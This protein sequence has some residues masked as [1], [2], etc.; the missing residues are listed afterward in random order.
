MKRVAEIRKSVLIRSRGARARLGSVKAQPPTRRVPVRW[1]VAT[2]AV[3]VELGA[4][5]AWIRRRPQ[6]PEEA[7]AGG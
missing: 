5:V 3:A 4:F 1:M 2:L 7:P 6:A